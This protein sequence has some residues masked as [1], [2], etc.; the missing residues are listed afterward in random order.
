MTWDIARALLFASVLALTVAGWL[1]FFELVTSKAVPLANWKSR[2]AAIAFT[3]G[4]LL[5]IVSF[6]VGLAR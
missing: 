1:T 5:G 3:A 6:L 4:V 2:G